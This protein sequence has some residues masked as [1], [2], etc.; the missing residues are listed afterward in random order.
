[1]LFSSVPVYTP[2]PVPQGDISNFPSMAGMYSLTDNLLVR[3]VF[4]LDSIPVIPNENGLY[5]SGGHWLEPV[6]SVFDVLVAVLLISAL[7]VIFSRLT[8]HISHVSARATDLTARDGA[9]LDRWANTQ[10]N[11]IKGFG[12]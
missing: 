9:V 8:G 7:F 1:M 11:R 10:H 4:F 12:E 5:D 3:A 2:H 6:V